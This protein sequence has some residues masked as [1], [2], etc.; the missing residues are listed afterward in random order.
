MRKSGSILILDDDPDI[1]D[2]VRIALSPPHEVYTAQSG[3]EALGIAQ[4]RALD[5]V[6]LDYLLPDVSGLKVLRA[7]KQA[8]PSLLV[9]LMTGFGSEEVAVEAFRGG[10]RDY[11]KK[12]VGLSDLRARVENLLAARQK[13]TSSEFDGPWRIQPSLVSSESVPDDPSIRRAIALIEARLHTKLRLDQVAREAGM[14]KFCFCRHFKNVTGLTFREFLARRRIA[15]AVHLLRDQTRRVGEVYL[16]VG[17][18]NLSHFSRVFHKLIGR[19]PS[20]F[21][22]ITG[23]SAWKYPTSPQRP[24]PSSPS[25]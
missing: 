7:L 3:M 19:S 25:D 18:K 11:L 21:R 4:E 1:L 23:G 20:R 10:V 2:A 8:Y 16:D 22:Q 12:P 14:S 17:F 15:R 13:T 6:L 5:L 24:S 9:I